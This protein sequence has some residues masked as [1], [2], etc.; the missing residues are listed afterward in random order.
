MPRCAFCKQDTEW[1][2]RKHATGVIN[3]WVHR[4]T[5]RIECDKP[6]ATTIPEE[7]YRSIE[8]NVYKVS[9]GQVGKF[10]A[11]LKDMADVFLL[12]QDAEE[13]SE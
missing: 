4:S 12:N 9:N 11:T 6:P 5:G 8:G 7:T 2:V 10:V 1:A 13:K 3:N